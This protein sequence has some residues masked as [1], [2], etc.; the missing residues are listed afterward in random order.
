MDS[1]EQVV[2]EILWKEG[3]WVWKSFKV[4]LTAEDRAEIR[5]PKMPRWEIDI[6]AYDAPANLVHVVEC[7]SYFDNPG[8][9]ARWL[10]DDSPPSSGPERGGL[11]KL[12]RDDKLRDVVFR[13]LQQQLFDEKRCRAKPKMRLALVCGHT[14]K[15]ARDE[16]KKHFKAKGWDLYDEEWLRSKV[17]GMAKGGYENEVSAVVAKLLLQRI[18]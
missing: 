17:Q 8:V 11:F 13:R 2:S 18:D 1:F 3:L 6:V 7:K 9:G 14:K 5:K 16:L 12:F 15:S 10:K 4:K